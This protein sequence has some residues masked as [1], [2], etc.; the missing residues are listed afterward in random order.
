MVLVQSAA[1]LAATL[2]A[3]VQTR[4]DLAATEIE[5]ETLR[6]FSYL[7]MAIAA[8]FC[9]GIALVLGVFLAVLLY[10]ETHRV[11]ILLTLI[12]LFGITGIW[13]G[14]RVRRQYRMKP[15]LLAHTMQELSRDAGLLQ[16]PA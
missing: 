16:P 2:I 3:A 14:L 15:K 10:W 4:V 5:E 8:M 9:L 12:S 6:Y 7:L 13:I 11:G 1:R